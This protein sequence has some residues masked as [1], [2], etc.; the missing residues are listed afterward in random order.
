MCVLSIESTFIAA[1]ESEPIL[2]FYCI[3]AIN[4]RLVLL[5]GKTCFSVDIKIMIVRS[6]MST[7]AN[8]LAPIMLISSMNSHRHCM[9]R[10]AASI[11]FLEAFCA[12]FG[13]LLTPFGSL[14]VP[15]GSLLLTLALDFLTFGACWRKCSYLHEISKNK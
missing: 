15:L 4:S 9:M 12:A 2:M 10:S 11:C 8:S 5:L 14:L 6:F 3:F 13:S 1:A 7:S